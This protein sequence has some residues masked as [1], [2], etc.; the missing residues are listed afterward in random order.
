MN[1]IYY[2]IYYIDIIFSKI[3]INYINI[4]NIFI[5]SNNKN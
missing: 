5:I 2:T 4:D 1:E 3:S